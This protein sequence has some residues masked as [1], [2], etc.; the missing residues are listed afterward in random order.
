MN[1]QGDLA[2]FFQRSNSLYYIRLDTEGFY[3]DANQL[4]CLIFRY[5]RTEIHEKN[6]FHLFNKES[7]KDLQDTL[8]LVLAGEQST[9]DL[10]LLMPDRTQFWTR[11]EFSA[12]YDSQ[13]TL[14]GIIGIGNDISER[15]RAEIEKRRV[16]EHLQIILNN[17]EEAFIL[18]DDNLDILSYNQKADAM[19]IE[20]YGVPLKK[21]VPVLIF[22]S[23][24]NYSTL[25]YIFR[26]VLQGETVEVD[27]EATIK[28]GKVKMV[29]NTF[30]RV[31]LEPGSRHGVI[32]T[33]RDI[34]LRKKAELELIQTK[35]YFKAIIENSHDGLLTL[36]KD[37]QITEVTPAAFRILGFDPM[38]LSLQMLAAK[39]HP[40][41]FVKL[42]TTFKSV[43][44]QVGA[45]VS[46]EFRA[47][48]KGANE[49]RWLYATIQ[50]LMDEPSIQGIVIH[51]HDITERKE[52][53]AALQESEEKYR[54]LFFSNPQP[55]W[56]FDKTTLEILEVNEAAVAHY[57]YTQEEFRNMTIRDIRPQEDVSRLVEWV[58][59]LPFSSFQRKETKIWRHRK[60]NGE[61]ISVEIKSHF[62][63]YQNRKAQ[64]VS[65]NDL[66]KMVEAEQEL[67]KS[68]ERF[69]YAMKATSEAIWEYDLKSNVVYRSDSFRMMFGLDPAMN[70]RY[71][72]FSKQI[73]A[74][75][76]G[77]VVESFNQA[78]ANREADSWESEYQFLKSDGN[79]AFIS[80]KGWIIRD[81][82]GNAT[83]VVGSMRDITDR[84][85]Y[86]VELL[87]T[88]ERFELVGKATSDAL[89]DLDMESGNVHWGEGYYVLFGYQSPTISRMANWQDKVHVADKERVLESFKLAAFKTNASTW[90][91]EYRFYR[92]D[93]SVADIVDKALIMRDNTG[94]PFRI[95]GAMQDISELKQ[96]EKQLAQERNLLRTLID[97]IPDY[98]YVKDRQLRHI[99]NN[100]AN[101]ELIGAES[102]AKTIGKTTDDYFGGVDEALKQADLQVLSTGEPIVIEESLYKKE[103]TELFWLLTTKV[104]L[105]NENEEVIGIVGVSRD[106]TERK[107]IEESLRQTNERY[108]I[109]SKATNDAIWDLDIASSEILWNEGLRAIFGHAYNNTTLEWWKEHVHPDDLPGILEGRTNIFST[110][111]PGWNDE[112]RFRDSNGEY[113][114]VLDH[115]HI[116]SDDEGKPYRVIGA[117]MDITERFQLQEELEKQ[118]LDRQRQ[119]TEATIRA[120]EKERTELGRELHDNI[121]Q[122]LTTSKI[123]IEMAREEPEIRE[124]VLEKSYQYVSSAIDEIRS[125][126]KSLVPPSLGDIGLKEAIGDLI[127]NLNV[128]QKIQITLKTFGLKDVNL[129]NDL[130]LMAY[131]IIQE[132][133][134]NVLK[135]SKSKMAEIT[136]SVVRKSLNIIIR[137]D[138]IGFDQAKRGRGIGLNNIMSRA[139]LHHGSVEIVSTPGNGCT[140]KVSIPIK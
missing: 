93:G 54:F 14:T 120:Q 79:Y 119:I 90:K 60:K 53:E 113:K 127:E 12:D 92:A 130:K 5:H 6:F 16:Q 101:V 34:T 85:Q 27:R 99:I 132:Q 61:I 68:N 104:P 31:V 135:H 89:Y 111:T 105:K 107:R 91:S 134:N 94:K 69:L 102:E 100:K 45:I 30:K 86:E 72:D 51:F 71:E 124:Q 112:Y 98:I 20:E 131:R 52:A 117:M 47:L 83:R 82:D 22:S 21:N 81:G 138:G 8:K 13:G 41:D 63:D 73:H 122:I 64:L 84:K 140:L 38:Q 48:I 57:G 106:I 66:T 110:N 121:N 108:R 56:I 59:L 11:W 118:R 49:Y 116:L 75:D 37:S 139:E 125:L 33:S 88:K 32:Y 15:K 25:E 67:L 17:S 133:L 9:I 77:R 39:I 40:A 128:A 46:V 26:A 74:D 70:N 24:E 87:K 2:T 28:S 109:V 43:K 62:I 42:A 29:R 65:V 35:N 97:H 36:N 19:T 23:N 50:N 58:S 78:I 1:H 80:D 136:L 115:G 44:D 137:D 103:S 18:V 95:I 76:V 4:Y 123:Y 96:K 114:M 7:L 129:D 10:E 55:M 126:S 3:A